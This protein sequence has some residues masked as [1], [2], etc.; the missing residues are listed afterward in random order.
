MEREEAV[1]AVSG[2][3]AGVVTAVFVCPLDVLKTRLQVSRASSTS[4]AGGIKAIVAREGVGGMYKGLGPT[5]LALLPNWAVYFVVYDG[6]KRRL[7][8]A[9]GTGPGV[10]ASPLTHMAAAA[11]AG[12]TTI[13]VTNPLWVVKTRMQCHG[14]LAPAEAAA[15]GAGVAEAAAVAAATGAAAAAPA[16]AGTSGPGAAAGAAAGTSGAGAAGPGAAAGPSGAAQRGGNGGAAA[17][18]RG[19]QPGPGPPKPV[20][21]PSAPSTS[22]AVAS[23]LQRAPYRSTAEA[24]LRIAREE[25]LRGLYSGLAPSM[26]G[27]AHV[28]I[29]FPLY[30]AAKQWVSDQKA[31]RRLEEAA[32]RRQALAEAGLPAGGEAQAAAAAAAG[33][34][35]EEEEAAALASSGPEPLTVPELVATS[36]FAKVVAST[37]TYPHEVV[38][39]YMHLSG[40]GPL[41]GLRD[42][43]LAVWREDGLRGFYRGCG[44]NLLRTTPAAA[45]TFTTFELVS[46]ALRDSL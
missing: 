9:A 23:Y 14:M 16:V 8:A 41:S 39:S 27:I 32:A 34:S 28:A 12:V 25:G 38:R 5:L 22:A 42:A 4:I 19:P 10:P 40:S 18:A 43:V 36:A 2:A 6:L 31:V 37:A 15:A 11:G 33:A 17:A 29:Q 13:L 3:I 30:E 24:L 26:A 1:N 46:R 35:P 44:A 21:P 7:A 20:A 45:M